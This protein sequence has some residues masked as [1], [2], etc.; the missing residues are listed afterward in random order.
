MTTS[1]AYDI[2]EVARRARA[3]RRFM[4]ERG[5]RGRWTNACLVDRALAKGIDVS[6]TSRGR[7]RVR[8]SGRSYRFHNG[9]TDFNHPLASRIALYKDVSS[10][11]LLS[12]GISAPR[13]AILEGGHGARAWRWAEALAHLVLKPSNANQGKMVHVGITDRAEFLK[14]FDSIAR[15]YGR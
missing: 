12:S 6:A 11:R 14:V 3:A 9:A 15:S 4:A 7:V 8:Q 1:T 2:E 10:A 13:N 5:I